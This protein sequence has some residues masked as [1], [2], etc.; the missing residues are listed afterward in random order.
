MEL[1]LNMLAHWCLEFFSDGWS[2]F[3]LVVVS[4]V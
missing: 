3:D 2:L 4:G 1:A